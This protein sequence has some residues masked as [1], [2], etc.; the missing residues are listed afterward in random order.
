MKKITVP[1]S[2]ITR[3]T[4]DT[5]SADGNCMELINARVKNGSISPIGRPILEV[6]FPA[7]RKPVYIHTNSNFIHYISYDETTGEIYFEYEKSDLYNHVGEYIYTIP[8]L[9]SIESIG[10]TLIFVNND[11]VYYSLFIDGSYTY[12]GDKPPFP[13][14]S[15]VYSMKNTISQ[16]EETWCDIEPRIKMRSGEWV[17]LNTDS[18]TL[19]NDSFRATINK[20]LYNL[21]DKGEYVYPFIVR[22]ALRLFDGSYIMHSAPILLMPGGYSPVINVTSQNNKDG[23]VNDFKYKIAVQTSRI[24]L[25]C[26]LS[27]LQNWKDI[28]SSVDIFISKQIITDNIDKDITSFFCTSDRIS[29][30][31]N[32]L[33]E[34]E[35]IEKIESTTNFYKIK[36]IPI[37]AE[38][39]S[40][41]DFL[42]E[43]ASN[44]KDLELKDFL[45]DDI[46]THNRLTGK[47]YVYNS[48]LHIGNIAMKLTP[49]YPISIFSATFS[50]FSKIQYN[51]E[52]HI[53]TESGIKIVHGS[54]SFG[55]SPL[56]PYISYPDTRAFKLVIYFSYAG[57][58]YYKELV[59]K[60]HSLLNMAYSLES[61]TPLSIENN[62]FTVGSYNP[63]PENSLEITPNKLKVSDLGNPFYFPAKQTYTVSSRGIIGMAVATTALST[64]QFGQ[65]PLYAFTEEGIFALSIGSGT[66]AYSS[67]SPLSR[68]VCANIES[69]T[70]IDNAVVF[71]TE[72]AL[73]L[74]S[75]ST[76]Q[77]LSD[78]IEGYLP[79]TFNSSPVL[80]KIIGIPKLQESTIEFRD[81]I[82]NASIGYIYEEKEIIVSNRQYSYSYVYNMQSGEWHK[83]SV[84]ATK[85]L[86]SY[87]KTLAVCTE[88]AGYGIYNI[89][90][91]HR[92][93][94]DIAI[95]T[96]PVKFG[97]LT[98]K[99]ILQSALRGIIKPSLSDV[100][101]RGEPVQF[102]EENINIFSQAGFYILG[103]NDA[104]HYILLAGTEKLNDIRDLITKMNKTKAYK[105][106]IFCLVGGVRTDV[107]IN[108]IE[109]MADETFENRLR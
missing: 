37:T 90:N 93:I 92:S 32:R 63:L 73:M 38:T 82:K 25:N 77:K 66:V 75:G 27:F 20:F 74:L 7:N 28:V 70:S 9:T 100:Y 88:K 89:Y 49:M 68:D 52:I 42:I 101:F 33:T 103:S 71:A 53:K 72:N 60:S 4:D 31:L 43:G 55:V 96:R 6:A 21:N 26:D 22:Y 10:N 81:Y 85:F 15:F 12:L 41:Y 99:R 104:E 109:V 44:T 107:A 30:S 64:G 51:T 69:I 87:P 36:S 14:L 83:L 86:N 5:I 8:N 29:F 56:S 84:S 97:S 106:F 47:T 62:S 11:S 40:L 57:K 45:T 105:Y 46:F 16:S 59:L 58:S 95:I 61:L 98:H 18:L 3:N 2:G 34:Q 94:N 39:T 48:R 23:Y 54:S 76:M 50:S 80:D 91:P 78:K 102:R 17:S 79:S 1:L 19:V 65:F 13:E 108:Y 67:V 24:L 35:T